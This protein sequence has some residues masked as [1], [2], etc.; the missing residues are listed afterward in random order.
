LGAAAHF[1]SSAVPVYPYP[2]GGYVA[3]PSY[4]YP[5]PL[6]PGFGFGQGGVYGHE[7]VPR[8]ETIV[9]YTLPGGW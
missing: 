2:V 1:G 7:F 3:F 5:L 4:P 9:G 6:A 8:D